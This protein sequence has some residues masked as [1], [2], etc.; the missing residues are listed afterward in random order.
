M[1]FDFFNKN[2][3]NKSNLNVLV[4]DPLVGSK[5]SRK[6]QHYNYLYNQLSKIC[7]CLISKETSFNDIKEIVDKARS[8]NFNPDIVYFGMGWFALKD[9]I[10]KMRFRNSYNIPLVGFLY[11]AQNY[12]KAKL[13]FLKNNKFSLIVTPLPWVDHYKESTGIDCKLL[14]NAG[15]STIFFDRKLEKKYDIGFS[16]A[17]H[18]NKL[19]ESGSFKTFNIRSRA[20]EI[21]S[22]QKGIKSFLNGSDDVKKRIPSYREY[23]KK[24]AQCKIWIATPGPYEEIVE[25]YFEIGMSKTLLFCNEIPEPYKK[26]FRDGHNCIVFKNDLSDFLE[27]FYY[28]LENEN[29]IEKI[30]EN[31]YSE[32]TNSHSYQSRAITLKK[33]FE[34]LI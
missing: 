9:E 13:D 20:Q 33:F 34:L 26:I 6:Y 24:I 23:A 30:I 25:R 15:D 21:L 7:N 4:V 2:L 11:K 16:G 29:L 31:S 1:I 22:E 12:L 19:Y 17:L 27:K 10:F 8:K 18:D 32:F 14:P 3:E 28:C 5:I